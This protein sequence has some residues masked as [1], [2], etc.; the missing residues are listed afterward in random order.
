MLTYTQPLTNPTNR[1]T[2]ISGLVEG[3]SLDD[4]IDADKVEDIVG[5]IDAVAGTTPA[6]RTDQA[7]EQIEKLL[8]LAAVFAFAGNYR[9]LAVTGLD[10]VADAAAPAAAITGGE[11]PTEA[12]F[13]ALRATVATLVTTVNDLLASLRAGNVLAE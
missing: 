13:N 7:L 1:D 5:L 8:G 9:S 6:D 4:V 3:F 10:A 2:G 11:P 12:E